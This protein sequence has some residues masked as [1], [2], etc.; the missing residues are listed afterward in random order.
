MT[1][2]ASDLSF[3]PE[4]RT[5]LIDWCNEHGVNVNTVPLDA[6][7][8]ILDDEHLEIEVYDMTANGTPQ[9][10]SELQRPKI[11]W[12]LVEVKSPFPREVLEG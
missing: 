6:D 3:R 1:R 4:E 12:L 8:E 7:V 2:L 11:R 10:D 9:W 5:T